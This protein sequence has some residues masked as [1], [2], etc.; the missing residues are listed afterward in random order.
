MPTPL[1]V[2]LVALCVVAGLAIVGFGVLA[3]LVAPGR[4]PKGDPAKLRPAKG[5]A[6]TPIAH[7]GL[8][9]AAAGVPEN[10]LAAFAAAM[11][12]GYGVELDLY[13]TTDDQLV[14]FH[15]DSLKRMC[16]DDRR[17]FDCSLEELRALRL[18][19]TDER[20][21]LFSEVLGL[22]AGRQTMIIEIKTAPRQ[23]E[24]C[25][26]ALAML[27][28]YDGPYCIES[29]HP[30]VVRWFKKHAPDVVRGQLA[31]NARRY[32][33]KLYGFCLGASLSNILTRPHFSAYH[34]V[35]APNLL[36]QRLYRALGGSGVAWTVRDGKVYRLYRRSFEV[37]IFEGRDT[38]PP[39]DR[40]REA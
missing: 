1:L 24:L 20:I 3:L 5:A 6:P 32:D 9:D 18:G 33:N 14:V 37:I 40:P 15:D 10:S 2:V 11:D 38:V 31:Q 13:L 36:T 26:K 23:Y 12:A 17:V 16:G 22:I 29:F 4:W 25:E 7:R 19:G 28:A 39:E 27:R 30:G 34:Y 35:E 21:P 8:H